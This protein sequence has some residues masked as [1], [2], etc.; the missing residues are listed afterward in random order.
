MKNLKFNSFFTLLV[1]AT[2]LLIVSCSKEEEQT[3]ENNITTNKTAN[4][5]A[6]TACDIVGSLNVGT[7]TYTYTYTGDSGNTNI[8]WT[9]T[10]SSAANILSGQ[11][12]S[13]ITI[14]FNSSC[15]MSA[16]GTGGT[17]GA[18]E[19]IISI[20]RCNIIVD[21]CECLPV[22][23]M[24]LINNNGSVSGSTRGE[25][26]FENSTT[27]N[28]DWSKVQS[29][30]I[31]IGGLIFGEGTNSS[32]RINGSSFNNWLNTAT[33]P[34]YK[35]MRIL[36]NNN[37]STIVPAPGGLFVYPYW[38]PGTA[39]EGWATI[40]FKNG[41]PTQTIYSVYPNFIE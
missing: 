11:G 6:S 15:T 38:S 32:V 29:V 40:T 26:W 8:N 18:C 1:L 41:C 28:F 10:P 5:L 9:I 37:T 12:T 31:Q 20:T 16:Y 33:S 23:K 35:N 3:K 25:F 34:A 36:T 19:D 7:G 13:T 27:C 22:L 39:I 2:S 14:T 4:K 30:K 17:A 21:P 24:G